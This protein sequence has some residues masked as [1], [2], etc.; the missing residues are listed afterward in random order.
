MYKL[1]IDHR[2]LG[3]VYIATKKKKGNNSQIFKYCMYIAGRNEP[4]ALETLNDQLMLYTS[5]AASA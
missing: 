5:E 2:K 1:Y 4:I 3:Y